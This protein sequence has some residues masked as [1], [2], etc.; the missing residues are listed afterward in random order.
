[1]QSMPKVRRGLVQHRRRRLSQLRRYS[2]GACVLRFACVLYHR[3]RRVFLFIITPALN[4]WSVLAG[5]RLHDLHTVQAWLG[6]EVCRA[7]VLLQ[8]L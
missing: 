2:L 5:S 4:S 1:M 3:T 6:H 7:V 8:L